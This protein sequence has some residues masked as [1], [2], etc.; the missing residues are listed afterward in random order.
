MECILRC[1][2]TLWKC[3]RTVQAVVLAGCVVLA[4]A[5]CGPEAP[6]GWGQWQHEGDILLASSA[7]RGGKLIA[8]YDFD[9]AIPVYENVR[10]GSFVLYTATEP[11]FDLLA[12][13]DAARRS[14]AL[15][16]GVGLALEVV[17]LDSG[18]AV[19]IEG[20]ILDSPGSRKTLGTTP[21]LHAHPEWQVAVPV[22]S[23]QER[24]RI[25]FRLVSESQ[26]Y[27]SSDVYTVTLVLSGN[28]QAS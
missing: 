28:G 5:A 23:S 12:F 20:Q 13:D 9:A 6:E 1:D 15:P 25:R 18:V 22:T 11:G 8:M 2:R 3:R 24:Y 7:P 10:V 4:G 27:E 19:K 17:E 26:G 14:Y 16:N 21:D